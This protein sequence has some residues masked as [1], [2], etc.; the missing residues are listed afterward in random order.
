L[1][2]RA[3][4]MVASLALHDRHADLV[5]FAPHYARHATLA[6][7]AQLEEGEFSKSMK[8]HSRANKAKH[9]LKVRF[10]STEVRD[11]VPGELGPN[12]EEFLP[13]ASSASLERRLGALECDLG[14][15]LGRIASLNQRIEKQMDEEIPGVIGKVVPVLMQKAFDAVVPNISGLVEGMAK[16]TLSTSCE[17]VV[18]ALHRLNAEKLLPILSSQKLV[19]SRLE[20]LE[21]VVHE[22]RAPASFVQMRGASTR[23]A[24]MSCTD[25]YAMA[26]QIRARRPYVAPVDPPLLMLLDVPVAAAGMPRAAALTDAMGARNASLLDY[27]CFDSLVASDSEDGADEDADWLSDILRVE[28]EMST[29]P[30]D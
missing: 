28:A 24:E 26:S 18:Q 16:T 22:L 20:K 12:A 21:A 23:Q 25:F 7:Q 10:G 4:A 11:Y 1:R 30:D 14:G 29:W 17:F 8:V 5:G 3:K 19:D 15:M 6:A 13:W 9:E 2:S 27:S